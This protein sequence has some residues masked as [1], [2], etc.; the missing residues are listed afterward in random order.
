MT[1][2]ESFIDDATGVAVV[3]EVPPEEVG[4]DLRMRLD[5][6]V[7]RAISSWAEDV[8]PA[9]RKNRGIFQ[10]DRFVTPGKVYDQMA[11]AYDTLDDDIVGGVADTSENLAFQKMKWECEDPDQADVWAQIGRDLDLD[12]WVRQAWRELFTV[13]QFY[14]VRWWGVKTYKV[15]GKRDGG[16][17][18]KKSFN[19]IVPVGLGFLDPTRVVPV[20]ANVF[21]DTELAWMAS[22]E[23]MDMFADEKAVQ[24]DTL[25]RRLFAG[26]YHPTEHEERAFGNEDIDPERLML[27]NP[28]FTFKHTLTKSPFER[29][30]R[31]RMRSILPLLDLKHQ[32]REMDRA[33]LL[34]GINFIVLVTRGTDDRPTNKT[35]VEDTSAQVRGQSRSPVI[36][37]DHRIKIEI[38]TTDQQYVLDNQKWSTIDQRIMMRLWGTFMLTA[39]TG[40]KETSLTIGRVIARSLAARRHMLKRTIEKEIIRQVTEHP[41]NT[42]FT[43][44]CKITFSPRR[45]ELEFDPAVATIVQELRDRGDI[46]RE[47][48]LAE[49]GFDQDMEAKRRELEDDRY[50]GIFDPVNVPFDSPDKTTPGGAGR[51]AKTTTQSGSSNG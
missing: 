42:D 8:V 9:T 47:S 3:S 32:L 13:S 15:R 36:V 29:W 38:I 44:E 17:P 30:A 22:E 45:M 26:Q 5:P 7:A 51:K 43:E 19:L 49:F 28:D 39:D 12:S 50:E 2:F 41:L 11:V 24:H 31:L 18:A 23:E 33:F 25:V 40:N 27:L 48:I 6:R 10:R 35:E 37:S 34:G 14:A 20:A 46:S 16:R 4:E 1:D 21:G